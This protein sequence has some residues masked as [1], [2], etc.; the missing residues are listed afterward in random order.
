M[1]QNIHIPIPIKTR[2]SLYEMAMVIKTTEDADRLFP[3]RFM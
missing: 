3:F 1:F 2:T